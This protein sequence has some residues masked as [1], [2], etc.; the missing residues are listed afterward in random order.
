MNLRL[1]GKT[2]GAVWIFEALAMAL[3]ALV[4]LIYREPDGV[5]FLYTIALLLVLGVPLFLLKA[6]NKVFYARDG[7]ATVAFVWVTMS[8]FGALPLFLSGE[9]PTFDDALFEAISG[10]TTTGATILTDVE[11]ISRGMLFWR[12]FSHWIGGMGV[13]VLALAILPSLGAKSVYLMQAESPGPQPGK[14][15]PKLAQSAR[16]LYLMYIA[17]TLVQIVLLLIAGMPLFDA[18]IHAFGTAGTGGFSSKALSVGAYSNVWIEVIITVFMALFGVNFTVYF[19]MLRRKFGLAT[20]NQELWFYLGVIVVTIAL[21]VPGIMPLY[22]ES[23]GEA[24]RHSSFQVSTIITTTGY[25]TTDFNLWP[26]YCK[27]LLM[28]LMVIGACAGSTAG[29]L[30]CVRVLILL[31]AFKRE[32]RRILHP[33]ASSYVTLDGVIVKDEV[34]SGVTA[35]FSAY[36]MIIVTATLLVSFDGHDFMSTFSAVLATI[37][38]VGPGF[39]LVGPMGSF[40]VFSPFSKVVLS[41]CMLAGRLEIFPLLVLVI[42]TYWRRGN[43]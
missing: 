41:I 19:L 28:A 6:D 12:S 37:G 30:K 22:G 31:K 34:M 7:F 23:F 11:A 36:V 21:I 4:S 17:L 38:N 24:L 26:L 5:Y 40:A 13:L 2:L 29:G 25:A 43:Q 14:L 9:I 15:V 20:K 10:F 18:L 16:I 27:V 3:S 8:V 1:I 33:R 32:L 35:F 42:P 39:G